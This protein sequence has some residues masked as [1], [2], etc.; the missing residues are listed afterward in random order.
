MQSDQPSK[1]LLWIHQNFVTAHQPGNSRA[2]YQIS[3]MLEQGWTVDVVTGDTGYLEEHTSMLR[4][5]KMSRSNE[6][7]A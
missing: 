3:S 2:I 5:A 7:A 1:R 4:M 6:K